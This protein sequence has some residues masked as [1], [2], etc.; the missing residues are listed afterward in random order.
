MKCIFISSAQKEFV[1]ERA[2]LRDYLHADPLLR[3]FF[4]VFLFEDLPAADRR[5]DA[6]YLKEVEA[7]DLY[8]GLFGKEN[9]LPTEQEFNHASELGKPRLIYVKGADDLDKHPKMRALIKRAGSE[10]IRRRFATPEDLKGA[11]YASLVEYLEHKCL[12]Q[13][14]PFEERS[15]DTASLADIDADAVKRFV[16]QARYERQFPLVEDAPVEEVLTH[17]SLLEKGRPANA[18]LLL[19]GHEPH[20]FVP[21][22]EVR[23]MHFHGVDVQRPAPSYRVFK[24]NLFEQ[25]DRATDFALSVINCS[26]GTRAE[27]TQ[28]PVKYEIPPDVI[29]EAIVNAIVHRDYAS[30][31]AV[32]VSVF[33]DRIEVWNPGELLPPLTVESLRHPHRS[34]LRNPRIA[35]TLFL[36]RYIEKYGT[37][38]VMMI[39]ESAAHSLPEPVFGQ[40]SGEFSAILWRNW[41][42]DV[43]MDE[44]GL[45]ARQKKA[46]VLIKH[47]GRITNSEY[48]RHTGASRPTAKRDLESLVNKGILAPF[49]RGRG[50]Y[51]AMVGKRLTNGSNG[52]S[53]SAGGNGS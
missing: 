10:L 37:G 53:G 44:L 7:C 15:C 43:R 16:R 34:V 24:G 14:K 25:V 8:I 18:A 20:H 40:M 30:S 51:Y 9:N 5:A 39:R 6:V 50:A 48:Q 27:S 11:V 12:I 49:G 36:A 32:Q 47:S 22:A 2:A 23:C 29:R 21:A 4:E 52:S 31:E 17:L 38:T 3:R 41:L 1:A 33:A 45:S 13:T 28:A 35:E 26:V 19:F 46:C 42:T